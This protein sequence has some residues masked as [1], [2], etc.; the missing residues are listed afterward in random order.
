M[1]P[2]AG[3]TVYIL[4]HYA[5]TLRHTYIAIVAADMAS[6]VTLQNAT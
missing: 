2:L 5:V 1:P 4:R 6:A 3:A